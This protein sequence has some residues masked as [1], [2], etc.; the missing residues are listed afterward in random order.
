MIIVRIPKDTRE[1]K[2]R[3]WLGLT[4][5][6]L[7]FGIAAIL[8]VAPPYMLNRTYHFMNQDILSLALVVLAAPLGACGFVKINGMPFERFL[9]NAFFKVLKSPNKRLFKVKNRWRREL[10]ELSD[11][12]EPTKKE[13]DLIS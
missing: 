8:I 10:N 9:K 12:A 3:M 13:K 1:Y 7:A 11:T 2:E 5:R 4:F 6:Q